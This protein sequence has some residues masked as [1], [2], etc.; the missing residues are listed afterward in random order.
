MLSKRF[1]LILSLFL[2]GCA[3]VGGSIYEM[4][5]GEENPR[6]REIAVL[7]ENYVD[8]WQDVKP[9]LESRCI[10]CHGCY[11]APCQL[12]LGSPDGINRG[13]STT[14]VYNAS[15]LLP[16][17]L[18]RLHQ[19]ADSVNEWRD[20][21][22][23]AVINE[24]GDSHEA[25]R[26]AGIMYRLLKQKQDNPLPAEKLLPNSF[27][28]D[29]DS[30]PVCP[31][32]INISNYEQQYPLWGMPYALPGLEADEHKLLTT[33][34]EQGARH[35]AEPA[36]APALIDAV[37]NW[38]G[39]LNQPSLKVQLSA[40]YIYEHLFLMNLYFPD[41]EEGQYFRLVRS[42]T[43][44]GEAID[45]LATRRPYDDPGMD[46]F[47]YRLHVVRE[48]I[49]AKSH[50]PYV[51]DDK[52]LARWQ[53]LFVQPDYDVAA[54]PSHT[55]EVASNPFVAFKDLPVKSRYQFLL[56]D[57]QLFIMGFIKGP[58]CRGQ[59]ALNVINDHFWVFFVEPDIMRD[60]DVEHFLTDQSINLQL[61]AQS[62]DVLFTTLPSW[63]RYSNMQR[64]FLDSKIAMYKSFDASKDPEISEFIWDGD[65]HN[66]NAALTIFRHFDSASVEKGLIGKPPKTSWV[67]GYPLF[68]RI[69]YLLVAGFDVYGNAGHQLLTRVYMD[70]LRMEGEANFLG[71]LPAVDREKERDFW[72]RGA[73]SEIQEFLRLPRVEHQGPQKFKFTSDNPKLELYENLVNYLGVVNQN[74]YAL[75]KIEADEKLRSLASLDG[76]TG[77]AVSLVPQMMLLLIE[78]PEKDADQLV[79]ILHHN[80]H[81][82]K[83]VVFNESKSRIPE[84]DTIGVYAGVL[85]AYPNVF[86]KVKVNDVSTMVAQLKVMTSEDDYASLL[87]RYGVRRTDARFWTH[88]D[89][90]ISLYKQTQPE[91]GGLLDYNRLENR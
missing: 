88:S 43:P 2:T 37:K 84:E 9:V 53:E 34:L 7:P 89:R 14:P 28:L 32:P 8:Y 41:V 50:I 18:T 80:A 16:A 48:T 59:I 62:Q 39:F 72:Y 49:V 78:D 27:Q 82:N 13:G 3:I 55:P 23:H 57:A 67:I 73:G 12:K 6:D 38:E 83:S 21:G 45:E 69:H 35:T 74:D 75:S 20:K 33:W 81:L 79:T 77:K 30:A 87:D 90:V 44:P 76:L 15:R 36:L 86:L 29:L 51:L 64:E 31:S 71:A 1:L 25:N 19:D 5:Y 56:D 60:A 17:T 47:Y 91:Y 68:E 24:Y 85:G 66:P 26:V 52:R 65:K 42:A 22:F 46:K 63:R 11:D 54:L 10:V 61:P 58:V 70:F 40:R 4:Q